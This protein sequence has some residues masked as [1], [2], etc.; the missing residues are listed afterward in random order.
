MARPVGDFEKS[1]NLLLMLLRQL[2]G[3]GACYAT[4]SYLERRM[5]KCRTQVKRY[6]KALE[7]DGQIC[8]VTSP[9]LKRKGSFYRKRLIKIK[10]HEGEI[11]KRE[12]TIKQQQEV[13]TVDEVPVHG[14]AV[15]ELDAALRVIREEQQRQADERAFFESLNPDMQFDRD[16]VLRELEAELAAFRANM[17]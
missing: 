16:L 6:L 9:P 11:V 3:I 1:K 17:E 12:W 14:V 15:E 8:M 2:A 7:V 10:T 4:T 5:G 13:P